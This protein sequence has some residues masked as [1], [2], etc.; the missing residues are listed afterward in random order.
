MF[1]IRSISIPDWLKFWEELEI[2]KAKCQM[3][4]LDPGYV[5]LVAKRMLS[6]LRHT[7]LTLKQQGVDVSRA[8]I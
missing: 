6:P 1:L 8:G 5:G 2:P 7:H 3:S 4:F